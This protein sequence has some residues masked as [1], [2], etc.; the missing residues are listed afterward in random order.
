M[1]IKK[2]RIKKQCKGCK[3]EF[4]TTRPR[5]IYCSNQC[6]KDYYNQFNDLLINIPNNTRGAINELI[7]SIDLMKRGYEVFRALS[8]ACSCDLVGFKNKKLFRVEVTSGRI[9][10]GKAFGAIHNPSNYDIFAVVTNNKEIYYTGL[11]E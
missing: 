3:K 9:V 8:P 7:V 10:N 6:R 5:K 4:I 2:K 11:S 1:Y